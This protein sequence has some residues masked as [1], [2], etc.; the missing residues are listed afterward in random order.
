MSLYPSKLL[1]CGKVAIDK[2]GVL[3]GNRLHSY[4][5][6]FTYGMK[7]KNLNDD[8][9]LYITATEFLTGNLMIF[10]K[11]HTPNVYIADAC[12]ASSG[13]QGAFVP[14]GIE[15]SDCKMF[16]GNSIKVP[17]NDDIHPWCATNILI[18][19]YGIKKNTK[20][21]FVDGGNLGNCRT[22]I[23]SNLQTEDDQIIGVTFTFTGEDVTPVNSFVDILGQTI[24]IMM[25]GAEKLANKYTKLRDPD[26]IMLAPD[27]MGVGT[28]DF[29]LE[30]SKKQVLLDSGKES[31][32]PYLN[33]Y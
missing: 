14:F 10:S 2:I 30:Y 7:F 9:K 3:K 5:K 31:I 6:D 15:G 25:K 29:E 18:H 1:R 28:I 24:S 4:L 11:E 33:K 23:A 19:Q 21:F 17:Q 12:R 32:L 8:M 27:K 20:L 26:I 16:I 22:D 13:I